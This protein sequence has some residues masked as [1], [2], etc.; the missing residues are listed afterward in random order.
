[1]KKSL[2][3]WFRKFHRWMAVPTAILIPI[4]VVVRLVGKPEWQVVLK[5]YE[6]D[7]ITL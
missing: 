4:F 5:Q 3:Q 7:V 1:M 2:N 6:I